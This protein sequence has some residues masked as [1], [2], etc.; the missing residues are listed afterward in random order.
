MSIVVAV[1]LAYLAVLVALAVWSRSETRTVEGYFLAGKKLPPW[2]VA[3]STNA[4]GESGWL[5]LGL[6]GMGYAAGAQA[7]WVVAGELIGIALA[8]TVISRRIKRAADE[9][10]SI[11]VPDV[12]AA[13][14]GDASHVLR[15][16]AILII[17]TM[18]TA[19]VAAQMVATGKAFDGFTDLDYRWGVVVGAGVIILYTLVGGFKAV[20]WSDLVQGLLMLF[21]LLILPLVAIDAAGGWSAVLDTLESDS[22]GL[23]GPWGPEGKSFAAMIGIM[24]FLA[25]GIPFMGVPQLMVRFMAARSERSLVPAMTISITV[26]ALFDIGAVLT[27]MAGRALYPGLE[28]PERILPLLSVELLH[29]VLAGVMMVVVLA[30]IMSTVDS[31]LLLASSAVVRDWLQK[32]RGSALA[33]SAIANRGKLVTLVIGLI[34]VGFALQQSPLIFWFVLFAWSGLGAAFGPPL[35]CLFWYPRTNR[36]GVIAGMVGGFATT[37]LW[38]L[39]FKERFYDLLEVIPGFAV[40]LLLTILVS[41]ASASRVDDKNARS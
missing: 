16:I 18:V 21:G 31:L 12:L 25:V 39:L 17:L 1:F 28:D 4:T 11:T 37:V 13:K 20:A 27:G 8:W 15:R 26:I 33:E 34:G 40:G 24:S 14:L 3:F 36:Y 6:T 9:T 19:Y 38:V 29:P 5:L 32:I 10:D 7:F 41:R 22:P 2:V 30:A 35:I 23:L